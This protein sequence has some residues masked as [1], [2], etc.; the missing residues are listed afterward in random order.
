MRRGNVSL[1]AR[2]SLYLKD[3]GPHVDEIDTR[4]ADRDRGA[5]RGAQQIGQREHRGAADDRQPDR[6]GHLARGGIGIGTLQC[7]MHEGIRRQQQRADLNGEE[8]V[9]HQVLRLH[10]SSLCGLRPL[11]RM[12]YFC[13]TFL[14]GAFLAG[15]FLAGALA[16]VL[17]GGLAAAFFTGAG[18]FSVFLGSSTP[19]SLA[20][21]SPTARVCV[22][23][24]PSAS[25][26][27]STA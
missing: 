9:T 10:A 11:G 4:G 8:D 18:A 25:C 2:L 17:A 16:G 26:V 24:V 14:A 19:T 1:L 5:D 23:T 6:L 21:R 3:L 7:G 15:A 13:V 27:S 12:N 20:A 22:A